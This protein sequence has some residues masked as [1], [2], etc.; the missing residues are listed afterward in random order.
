MFSVEFPLLPVVRPF[1]NIKHPTLGVV[2]PIALCMQA[3]IFF[4]FSLNLTFTKKNWSN[5]GN[6][7]K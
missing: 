6:A 7:K 3:F 4:E 2:S 1:A 5:D